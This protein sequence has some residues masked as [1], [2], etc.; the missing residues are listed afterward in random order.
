[1]LRQ[2]V[3]LGLDREVAVL[4]ATCAADAQASEG[5]IVERP[6]RARDLRARVAPIH[7][8]SDFDRDGVT[9]I[10]GD[11]LRAAHSD[12]LHRAALIQAVTSRDANDGPVQRSA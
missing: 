3:I 10:V 7:N 1:M 6:L 8:R 2:Q 4:L 9:R 5:K 11:D 12:H